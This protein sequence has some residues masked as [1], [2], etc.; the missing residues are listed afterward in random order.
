MNPP[1]EHG[2]GAEL[3]GRE[4]QGLQPGEH[5]LVDFIFRR[6]RAGIF[7]RRGGPQFSSQQHQGERHF[8]DYKNRTGLVVPEAAASTAGRFLE[9]PA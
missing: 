8:H 2:I 5:E 6:D 4:V 9:G 1:D 3:R 7:E